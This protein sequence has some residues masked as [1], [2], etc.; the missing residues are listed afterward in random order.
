MLFIH[1]F[2]FIVVLFLT[3]FQPRLHYYLQFERQY[4]TLF[5]MFVAVT[6][7]LTVIVVAVQ[8]T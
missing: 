8:P 7:V 3:H 6:F 1:A 5:P 2:L 4:L